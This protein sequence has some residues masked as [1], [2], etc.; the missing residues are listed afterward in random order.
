MRL[1]VIANPNAGR[2]RCARLLPELRAWLGTTGHQIQWVISESR[3]HLIHLARSG[4]KQPVDAVVACGGDG[5]AHY[6]LQELVPSGVALGM[7]PVGTGNDWALGLGLPTDL[8]VACEILCRGKTKLIDVARAG[9]QFYVSVAGAGFDS[10]VNRLANQNSVWLRGKAV[11]V[12]AVFRTLS[13]FKPKRLE[14]EYDDHRFQ[15]VAMF[16]AVGNLTSYGGGVKI[17]PQAQPDDGWLDVCIV[18][19]TSRIELLRNLPLAY[20]GAHVHHPAIEMHRARR[21]TIS[22]PDRMELFGDGEYLQDIPVTIEVIPQALR[23]IVP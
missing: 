22:S 10:E 14:I 16:V 20:T 13:K 3:E 8:R 12:N 19:K 4:V 7:I 6:I 9:E 18:K 1:L 21:V 2:G 23:V 5:T 17:V 11:Y 15:G